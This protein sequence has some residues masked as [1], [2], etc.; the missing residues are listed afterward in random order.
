MDTF[1]IDG[2]STIV[3]EVRAE[4]PLLRAYLHTEIAG[5]LAAPGFID[6][7]PGYLLPDPASQ[8]GSGQSYDD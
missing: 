1:V 4:A 3:E 2:R 8:Q 7:L 5:L 6:A